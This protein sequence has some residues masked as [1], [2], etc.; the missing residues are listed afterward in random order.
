MNPIR[1]GLAAVALM[2]F[3]ATQAVADCLDDVGALTT[4]LE[5]MQTEGVVARKSADKGPE[6]LQ[7]TSGSGDAL[8]GDPL[9]PNPAQPATPEVPTAT[10][11]SQEV[12][13]VMPGAD[14]SVELVAEDLTEASSLRDQAL[15]AAEAGDEQACRQMLDEAQTLMGRIQQ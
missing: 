5:A 15:M 12:E 6:S 10:P 14:A 8:T 1:T 3:A 11:T 13:G 2:S 4:K 9:N 7:T